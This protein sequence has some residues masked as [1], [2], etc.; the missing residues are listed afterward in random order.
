MAN[1]SSISL[2]VSVSSTIATRPA[3][4]GSSRA[5]SPAAP[6]DGKPA[7]SARDASARFAAISS[8]NDDMALS[9]L[10]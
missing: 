8:R 3:G 7:G 6:S 10:A 9:P 1:W 4:G 2:N 5:A